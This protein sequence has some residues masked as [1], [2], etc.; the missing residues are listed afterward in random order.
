MMKKIAKAKKEGKKL[1]TN[2]AKMNG[3]ELVQD[4]I[5]RT[6]TILIITMTTNLLKNIAIEEAGI[7]FEIFVQSLLVSFYCYEYKTAASSIDTAAGLHLFEKQWIYFFG[8]GLPFAIF[9]FCL[10]RF[11]QCVFFFMFPFLVMISVNEK[12]MGLNL[13]SE[14]R[15]VSPN[16]VLPIFTCASKAKGVL[17][18]WITNKFFGE[19]L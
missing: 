11:G 2:F 15:L 6:I 16:F 9:Q 3:K 5:G 13:V 14:S 18:E 19:D 10:K 12:G 17:L 7:A 4:L 8:F 1:E